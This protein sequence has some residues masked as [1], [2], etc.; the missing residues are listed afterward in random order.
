MNLSGVGLSG[1]GVGRGEPGLL[2]EDLKAPSVGECHFE[3]LRS[4]A[5]LVELDDLVGI[6]LEEFKEGGLRASG[7]LGASELELLAHSLDVLQIHHE[8]L[9]PLRGALAYAPVS[10]RRKGIK[11][12]PCPVPTVM[13]WACT[14]R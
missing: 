11:D 1:N 9:D 13:S 14:T 6:T 3:T 10:N 5:H 2:A 8:L 12:R 4:D 7:A